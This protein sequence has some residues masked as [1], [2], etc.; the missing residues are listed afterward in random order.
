MH[1][2]YE[3]HECVTYSCAMGSLF[4]HTL[5]KDCVVDVCDKVCMSPQVPNPTTL[6]KC[7]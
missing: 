1:T 5:K 6:G 4:V 2:V 7:A 3:H